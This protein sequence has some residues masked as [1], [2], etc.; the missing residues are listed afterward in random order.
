MSSVL[1]NREQPQ[2]RLRVINKD[3]FTQLL[4]ACG[5]LAP[6][7]F[8]AVYLIEGATRP[9]Y[10]PWLHAVGNL[11][12]SDQG[13]LQVVNFIVS[14][15]L[16]IGFATGLR[17]TLCSGEGAL[18][19]PVMIAAAGAGLIL[20]GIFVIDPSRGYPPGTPA[21]LTIFPTLHG[22]LHIFFGAIPF[23][24]GLPI[25]CYALVRRIAGNSIWRGWARYSIDTGVLM[26]AFFVAFVI[27]GMYGGPAG[28]FE[29]VSITTGLVWIGL[30][31]V[32]LLNIARVQAEG[33]PP[34][35]RG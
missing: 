11:S 33:L 22:N 19:G 31:S 16:I 24:I 29:R 15:L 14:G 1:N 10:D 7:L 12:L 32:R 13:W 8:T 17:Q 9:G 5:V 25:A 6:C 28:L 21:G 2:A 3:I 34:T 27:A 35:T 4:L 18:L 26:L 23:F 30:L 20:A